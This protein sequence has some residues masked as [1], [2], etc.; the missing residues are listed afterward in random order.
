MRWTR[1][2]QD[3]RR[4]CEEI[5][6]TMTVFHCPEYEY[7]APASVTRR[8]AMTWWNCAKCPY[9]FYKRCDGPRERV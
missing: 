2:T 8:G 1:Q 5:G 3:L 6:D 4:T 7:E 9:F